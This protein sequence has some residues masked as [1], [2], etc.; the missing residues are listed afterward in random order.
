MPGADGRSWQ[1]RRRAV[2]IAASAERY[3]E[4]PLAQAVRDAAL[5][6]ERGACANRRS[7]RRCPG[8]GVRAPIDGGRR[9]GRHSSW[10]RPRL[11]PRSPAQS[12]SL[13]DVARPDAATARRRSTS[14]STAGPRASCPPPTRCAAEVPAALAELRE[15]GHQ[16]HRAADRRQ[17]TGRGRAGRRS[18]A[19]TTGRTCCPRTRFGS[20][21]STRPQG[22]TV[23]MIGDG[24]NDAPALAQADV[25]RRDGRGRRGR[26]HRGRAR[27][28]DAR[29]LEPRARAVPHRPPHHARRPDEPGVHRPSTTSWA[30]RWRR[31]ASCRPCSP[32]PR[33]RFPIWASSA[34]PRG[35]SG[36]ND[37]A[38]RIRGGRMPEDS[39]AFVINS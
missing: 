31:S 17:R 27:G 23:V 13:R 38:P 5:R 4:H 7:S 6:H 36:R 24:V 12:R 3:S 34:I 33:S 18:S 37:E 1:P 14:P 10:R 8:Q 15:L 32:P 26:G 11:L 30:C 20:C 16:A 29:G 2:A 28:A 22:H 39:H 19:S 21:A 35:C 25:G 9:R